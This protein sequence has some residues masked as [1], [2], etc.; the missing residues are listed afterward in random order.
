[1]TVTAEVRR[2]LPGTSGQGERPVRVL[3]VVGGMNRGGTETW[4]VDL[5]ARSDS[6][7]FQHDLLTHANGVTALDEAVVAA[8][9]SLIQ[10]PRARNLW[11]YG[12][13]LRA[14]MQE[15]GPYDAV[16]AHLHHFSAL[17]LRSAAQAG[18][19]VRIAHSHSDTRWIDGRS[20]FGR[21]AYLRLAESGIR[22]YA[23]QCLAVS[24]HAAA[25][26]F[27]ESWAS[28]PRVS[29]VYCGVGLE[30]FRQANCTPGDLRP[31]LGIPRGAPVFLHIGRFAEPKNHTFLIDIF[32]AIA[33]LDSTAWFVLAGDGPLRP[34]IEA[35]VELAGI[36][37]RTLLLGMRDDV[38]QLLGGLAD[39]VL[40]PSLW[41]GLPITL[42]E[43]QAAGIPAL[44]SDA[45]T[46]EAEELPHLLRRKSL[47]EPAAEWAAE[48]VEL[49]AARRATRGWEQLEGSRFDIRTGVAQLEAIYASARRREAQ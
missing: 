48:A 14:L 30:K 27:G 28:D 29:V 11:S 45:I 42:I 5:I 6:A 2:S 31:G 3:H 4:L 32:R 23:T 21:R 44:Y 22:R 36:S 35:Q 18:V 37:S 41:E 9:A 47:R 40:L 7:R 34:Q 49:A 39:V 19:P 38:P 15:H 26:L 46:R 1:M 17:A 12:A 20:G 13:K 43:S 16:H 25:G 33:Q 8:G 10:A 24:R